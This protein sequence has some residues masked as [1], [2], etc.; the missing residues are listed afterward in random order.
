MLLTQFSESKYS[1]FKGT[2]GT[3]VHNYVPFVAHVPFVARHYMLGDI[4]YFKIWWL[5]YQKNVYIYPQNGDR[6]LWHNM[7]SDIWYF[8]IWGYI[9]SYFKYAYMYLENGDRLLWH[10][11]LSDIWY[12]EIWSYIFLFRISIYVPTKWRWASMG[13]CF[14]P[15]SVLHTSYL[16]NRVT[17]YTYN[18]Q[19]A[20]INVINIF[21]HVV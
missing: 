10:N 11:M 19:T 5:S 12:F 1:N 3:M 20:H 8:E 9:Y 13:H 16:E 7:L 21:Q 2:N 14:R 4:W 18:C 6:L 17:C 15:Y